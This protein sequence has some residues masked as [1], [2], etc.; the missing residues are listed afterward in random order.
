MAIDRTWLFDGALSFEGGVDA[1]RAPSLL[2]PNQVA[3]A[4]NTTFRGGYPRSR[5]HVKRLE[6][7]VGE[8]I[9]SAW[10]SAKFQGA[11]G[12]RDSNGSGHVVVAV[13]GKTYRL[14]LNEHNPAL[15]DM[16]GS[17][18]SLE[19]NPANE[20][21]WFVQAE[22]FLIDQDG[23][24]R[25]RI[26]DGTRYYRAAVDQIPIGTRMAYG[27]GR[28]WVANG[29]LYYGGDLI[30]TNPA[31]GVESILHFTENEYLSEGG[32]FTVG[33]SAGEITGMAFTAKQDTVSGEGSLMVFTRTGIFEFDAPV[34]RT[35]WADITQPLQRFSLL[36][37]GATSQESIIRVNGDLFFRAEDGIRSFYFARRDF[38][39]WGNTPISRE[40]APSIASD[41]QAWLKAAS[42]ANFD[43]RAL[44]TANPKL[45]T[46]GFSHRK[47]VALDFDLISG[48]RE[49][50][51]PAWEG[52]W[53]FDFSI[54]QILTV[55]TAQGRR[56]II[57]AS[58]DD[59][60]FAFWELLRDGDS[61]GESFTW[62]FDSRAFDFQAP[63]QKKSLN[64]FEAW[65]HGIVDD[66]HMDVWWKRNGTGCWSPWARYTA[67]GPSC[68]TVGC[69][70]PSMLGSITKSR[71]GTPA[72]PATQDTTECDFKRD[73]YDFQL[74]LRFD[75]YGSV[76]RIRLSSMPVAES[77]M[78]QFDDSCT[79][80]TGDCTT[81]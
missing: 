79:T 40:V 31:L 47:L 18:T 49:K 48:M 46:N 26:W 21:T 78:G 10:A 4:V 12:Y 80:L 63:V 1:G 76:R 61:G 20:R 55:D 57:V 6:Y 14:P 59:E 23:R 2:A 65:L 44:F 15:I 3:H 33:L 51:P 77:E 72:T 30:D 39:S 24:G 54:Y 53:E 74:R 67:V 16:V 52:E 60:T 43:N 68:P 58:D 25:A 32:A 8:G 50:L 75:G 19:N 9:V 81:C 70:P 5:P 35:A 64:A 7:T 71:V 62:G 27:I 42:S 41:G 28:L 56:C 73:G 36:D 38:G 11:A 13:G 17:D 45:G 66:T 29:N 34:D 69:S 37:Y 22:H